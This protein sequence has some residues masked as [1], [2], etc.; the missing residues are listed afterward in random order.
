MVEREGRRSSSYFQQRRQ[1]LHSP[2]KRGGGYWVEDRVG[3]VGLGLG[4]DRTMD[5][6]SIKTPNPKCR[7]CLKTDRK[8]D[9]AAG[10]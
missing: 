10:V 4:W 5:H 3:P 7:L 1:K 8:R 2:I 6:I 9:L